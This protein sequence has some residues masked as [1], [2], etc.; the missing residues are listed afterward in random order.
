MKVP[1]TWSPGAVLALAVAFA[2]CSEAGGDIRGG[3]LTDAGAEATTAPPMTEGPCVGSGTKWSDLY[4]DIF[5]PTEQPGSCS[6][7]SHCHGTAEG[8]GAQVGIHCFDEKGC[9]T[10]FIEKGLVS[11]SDAAAPDQAAL[12]VGLLRL[13][14]P[15]GTISGFMPETPSNYLYSPACLDRM[16]AWIKDG[17]PD[18]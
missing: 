1:S 9:R 5:G 14:K 15:D 13:R 12:F 16:K 7:R 6:F 8:R 10:S 17:A 3:D 11:A 18:N 4:R 2:A